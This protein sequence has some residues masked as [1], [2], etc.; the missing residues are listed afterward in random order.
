MEEEYNWLKSKGYLHITAQIDIAQRKTEIYNKVTDPGYVA[1]YSFYPLIHLIIDER[2][3]KKTGLPYPQ[4]A[5]SY[6]DNKGEHKRT[7]KNRPLHYATH[8]DAI[9]FGYYAE[10]LQKRYE[11]SLQKYEGLSD[12]IIAYRKIPT[13]VDDTNKS[14]IHFAHEIFEEIRTRTNEG[15]ECFVLAF[16]I[17]SFFS[18]LDHLMLK[19]AWMKL[20]DTNR[21]SPDHYNVF[22]AATNF[23]YIMRDELR[24]NKKLKSG[25]KSPFDEKE[26]AMIRNKKGFHSFFESPKAFRD[27]IKSGKL[28]IYKHPFRNDEKE[29]VGI[30]QGLPISAILAN[31]YLLE[32]DINILDELV[33]KKGCYYRRYSDDI[34]I[35]CDV[36][37]K[38]FV[39]DFVNTSIKESKVR[40]SEGKTEKF[41]FKVSD[42]HSKSPRLTC[43]KVSKDGNYTYSPFIYLGFE[44]NGS[45]A[46]IKSSNLSKFYRRMVF[47]VR[48]K[49][50]RALKTAELQPGSKPVV[51][52][53]QLYKLYSALDLSTVKTHTRW[54][55]LLKQENG[56]F[57]LITGVK[58]RP[59]KSNYFSYAR[60]ATEIMNEPKI[61]GQTRNH[62]KIFNQAVSWHLRA[63]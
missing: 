20:L 30:P 3:Y 26:L 51:Y 34:A 36:E 37:Q 45:H 9:I 52:R 46:L 42:I 16:D 38:D 59:L 6:I 62:K 29:P 17:K 24:I 14:T 60:R 19:K 4:R 57:R 5:H 11:I 33:N 1:R 50:K 23:S 44:F 13:G 22:K 41:H 15:R 58:K 12:C 2:K 35:I 28:K 43:F 47:A 18:R 54:K 39:E 63:K 61:Y 8:L 40:I 56:E 49:A 25:K 27:R 7:V 21:L 48:R 31:L 10:L 53:R 55:K 32:F